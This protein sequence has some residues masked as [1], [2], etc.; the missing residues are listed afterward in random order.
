MFD[1]SITRK[2][3]TA[4]LTN[5]ELALMQWLSIEGTRYLIKKKW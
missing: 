3:I 1:I 2:K 4:K 5:G